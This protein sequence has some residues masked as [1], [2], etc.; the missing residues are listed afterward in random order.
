[1]S[2]HIPGDDERVC[3]SSSTLTS[4]RLSLLGHLPLSCFIS[5][6][7]GS[8]CSGCIE[9]LRWMTIIKSHVNQKRLFFLTYN[10]N[11]S[12]P[13]L[14]GRKRTTFLCLTLSSVKEILV[15]PL[16]HSRGFGDGK[17]LC[18]RSWRCHSAKCG[19]C[20]P[21]YLKPGL[22]SL[23]FRRADAHCV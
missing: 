16:S 2:P 17:L 5:L 12:E 21:S 15:P 1:M 19:I 3:I 18:G 22:T 6:F 11:V 23:D 13:H 20:R 9:P 14:F 4:P 7:V 10:K 8:P